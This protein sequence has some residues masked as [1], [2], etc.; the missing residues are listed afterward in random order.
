MEYRR[1]GAPHGRIA[2][3]LRAG[4]SR[5]GL[6]FRLSPARLRFAGRLAAVSRGIDGGISAAARGHARRLADSEGQDDRHRRRAFR[7]A[8]AHDVPGAR[9]PPPLADRYV[10]G[11]SSLA[12]TAHLRP[13]SGAG[14]RGARAADAAAPQVLTPHTAARTFRFYSNLLSL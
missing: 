1:A 2:A 7:M 11:P 10:R 5:R 8:G 3:L 14:G 9:R 12:G 4:V 13:L 6:G